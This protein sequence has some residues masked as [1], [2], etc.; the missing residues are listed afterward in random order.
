MEYVDLTDEKHDT[1]FPSSFEAPLL[2]RH[3]VRSDRQT[4]PRSSM[5]SSSSKAVA[6]KNQK[7]SEAPHD[8]IFLD[9]SDDGNTP[10]VFHRTRKSP[11]KKSPL[12][13]QTAESPR[14]LNGS[15]AAKAPATRNRDG[16]SYDISNG[17]LRHRSTINIDTSDDE[18]PPGLST[19]RGRAK[20]KL[21]RNGSGYPHTIHESDVSTTSKVSASATLN[22]TNG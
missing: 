22:H 6:T 1:I 16:A 5:G 17:T 14:N 12:P 19:R 10:D 21:M 2:A 11:P 18:G 13:K 20:K 15:S 8:V 4:I 3:K 7:L 9:D